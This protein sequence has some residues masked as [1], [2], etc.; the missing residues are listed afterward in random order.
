MSP[1][2]ISN[3]HDFNSLLDYPLQLC[4]AT[5]LATYVLSIVTGNVSQVDRIWTFMPTI[6]TAYWALLPLW[7]HNS[8]TWRF[9]SPYVPEEAS[10]FA[11]NFSPRALLI[12][13][14]TVRILP[15]TPDLHSLTQHRQRF[16]GCSGY[17]TTPG[18]VAS[19]GCAF[20][21]SDFLFCADSDL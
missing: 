12:M 14:L 15:L 3:Y 1:L 10:N 8:S 6:Y 11:R 2:P 9:L 17:R 20:F 7:P 18:D 13:G 5:T 21:C 16:C 19:F 4:A